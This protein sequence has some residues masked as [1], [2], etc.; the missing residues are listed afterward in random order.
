MGAVFGGFTIGPLL[1][2]FLGDATVMKLLL[3]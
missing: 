2:G 1:G 3:V